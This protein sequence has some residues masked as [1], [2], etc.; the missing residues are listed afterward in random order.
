MSFSVIMLTSISISQQ[1][2]LRSEFSVEAIIRKRSLDG[3]S[4]ECVRSSCDIDADVK[5]S[6]YSSLDAASL[7]RHLQM[8]IEGRKKGQCGKVLTLGLHINLSNR[9]L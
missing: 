7:R 4:R 1:R 2:Q 8:V 5:P 3:G 9:I 6:Q